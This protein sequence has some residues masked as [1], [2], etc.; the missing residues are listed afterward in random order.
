MQLLINAIRKVD[1][2][3]ININAIATDVHAIAT[4]THTIAANTDTIAPDIHN[5]VPV[6]GEYHH[7]I[8]DKQYANGCM[9]GTINTTVT[10]QPGRRNLALAWAHRIAHLITNVLTTSMAILLYKEEKHD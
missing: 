6:V 2:I 9:S 8:V 1:T 3:A 10:A 4:N 5:L 7:L